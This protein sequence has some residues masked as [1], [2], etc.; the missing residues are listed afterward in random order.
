MLDKL[1]TTYKNNII[2]T[3]LGVTAGYYLAKKLGYEKT[4]TIIPFMLVG[5]LS[6]A[7]LQAYIRAKKGIPT[8]SLVK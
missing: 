8:A 1:T 3:V 5:S 7:N 6:G 4:L 2:G